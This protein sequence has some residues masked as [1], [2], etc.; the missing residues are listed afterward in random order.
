MLGGR[1]SIRPN[2]NPNS[3]AEQANASLNVYNAELVPPA[4]SYT[5]VRTPL[6]SN[7][8][9]P[10]IA[11]KVRAFFKNNHFRLDGLL[12]AWSWGAVNM[13]PYIQS[14]P[15]EGS[16][17]LNGVVRS[18]DFQT[19]LVRLHDWQMNRNWYIMWNASGSGMF[20]GSKDIRYQY[21]S[22][23]VSQINTRTSGGPGPV[24]MSMQPRPRFTAVQRISKYTARARYYNTTSAGVP[25]NTRGGSSNVNGT[26]A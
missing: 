5:G 1:K 20:R 19:S 2:A 11:P 8:R 12:N 15:G 17:G 23:R 3:Y 7:Y 26:G 14:L 6:T 13:K 10:T 4:T 9:E 21:P 18:S 22:F 24:G 25:R 16:A